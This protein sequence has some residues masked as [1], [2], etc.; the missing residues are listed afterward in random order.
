MKARQTS[1]GQTLSPASGSKSS[2]GW[3]LLTARRFPQQ[4][5]HEPT[6]SN[7]LGVLPPVKAGNSTWDLGSV[8]KRIKYLGISDMPLSS[9]QHG[10]QCWKLTALWYHTETASY[11]KVLINSICLHF[12]CTSTGLVDSLVSAKRKPEVRT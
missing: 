8:R 2:V 1:V 12:Y 3:A 11:Q 5:L 6:I 4:T 9:Q 7:F 10:E